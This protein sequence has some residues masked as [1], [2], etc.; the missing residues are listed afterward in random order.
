M[1]K[2]AL[3]CMIMNNNRNRI[4]VINIQNGDKVWIGA[5]EPT[6]NTINFWL[7]DAN[8]TGKETTVYIGEQ[9]P[10]DDTQLWIEMGGA[11]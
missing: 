5:T 1:L 3:M 8:E 10:I 2:F 6:D 9:P 4:R 11:A 7:Y